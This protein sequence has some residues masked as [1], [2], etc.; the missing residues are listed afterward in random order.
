MRIFQHKPAEEMPL[1]KVDIEIPSPGRNQIRIRV[2]T[3][4]VCRTDLHTVEGDI[5]PE[6]LP[7]TPGHQIVG[8]VD[9]LGEGVSDFYLGQKVGVPWLYDACGK[10]EYCENDSENLCKD[11]RFTGFHVDGDFAEY[12]ISQAS[13]SLAIP[14]EFDPV[15]SAPLLCAGIIG[16]RSLKKADLIPGEILGLFGFGASAHIAIQIAKYWNC[17]VYVFTRSANHQRHAM[18]LGADWVGKLEETP[19]KKID[20]SIIFAPAGWIVHEALNKIRPGGTVAINA[21]YL[22]AI[23]ELLY[24]L[25][26]GE[27]TLRS[28][29]N[30][31]YKDGVELISLAREIPI[32]TTTTKYELEDANLAIVDVKNSRIN[33][34]AVLIL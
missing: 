14:D 2:L 29:A 27:R 34:E 5:I 13:Y 24:R 8:T 18:D 30:A 3:C 22:T 7:I 6:K 15:D 33:G 21:I 11:G 9:K 4:G 1:K 23:P 20:R 25:L 32:T 12:V 16:Y 19:N 26:Y 28:V 31:T 17:E 10:C